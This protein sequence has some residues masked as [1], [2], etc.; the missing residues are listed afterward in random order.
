MGRNEHLISSFGR[1]AEYFRNPYNNATDWLFAAY[2]ALLERQ[3][4]DF[5]LKHW[6][7]VLEQ[8]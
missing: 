3:P 5:G 1:L 2:Q 7:P 6:L 8:S 4:D